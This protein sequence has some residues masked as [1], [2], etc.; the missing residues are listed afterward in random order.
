M[1]TR[2]SVEDRR[3]VAGLVAGGLALA[4]GAAVALSPVAG[5]VVLAA[6]VLGVV[7]LVYQGS[8]RAARIFLWVAA[9]GPFMMTTQKSQQ[10]IVTQSVAGLDIVRAAIPMV[11]LVGAL[12]IHRP[13]RRGIHATEL[14]LMAYL[15][16]VIVSG[17]WSIGATQTLVK[18]LLLGV[19]YLALGLLVRTYGTFQDA[20]AGLAVFI[21]VLLLGEVLQLLVIPGQAYSDDTDGVFRLRSVVPTIADNPLAYVAVLGLL[22]LVVG[23]GPR[24]TMRLPI[25]VILF[26][27]YAMILLGT[28]TRTSVLIAV[29]LLLF[30]LARIARERVG[31]MVL[32]L[33]VTVAGILGAA[34]LNDSIASYLLRGQS[35]R[36]I[37]TLTGRTPIWN[38]AVDYWQEA[39]WLGH[40]F[41][42]GHRLGLPPLPGNIAHST[43]DNTWLES[44]VDVGVVG[45]ALL[46]LFTV[47]AT[48]TTVRTTRRADVATRTF[49]WCATTYGLVISFVN[50]SLETNG[51]TQ[52]FLGFI[53]LAASARLPLS[54]ARR[55]QPAEDDWGRISQPATAGAS[56][57]TQW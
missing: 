47:V 25:R 40:G 10:D 23:I 43:L 1:T 26:G 51:V 41:Y 54:R 16:V 35:A 13:Q 22:L 4:G 2:S 19:T 37:S 24:W 6:V 55:G 28:R 31:A 20:I 27:T 39:R 32:L 17:M 45:M 46:A 44:L 9:L 14:L 52:I 11:A 48:W 21:H 18:G 34:M 36:D 29:V 53:F 5:G 3:V 56:V 50:P 49:V 57:S 38:Q 30:A 12:L 15:A 8:A 33:T 7:V 42:S